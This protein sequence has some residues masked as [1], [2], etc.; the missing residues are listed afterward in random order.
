MKTHFC[1]ASASAFLAPA[2]VDEKRVFHLESQK[3]R[4][5]EREKEREIQRE[6]VSHFGMSSCTILLFPEVGNIG[7]PC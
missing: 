2:A 5:R 3:R 7:Q 4:E 6:K 1:T